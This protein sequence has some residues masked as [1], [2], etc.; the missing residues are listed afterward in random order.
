MKSIW[1]ILIILMVFGFGCNNYKPK[2]ETPTIEKTKMADMVADVHIIESYIQNIDAKQRDSIKTVLYRELFEIH[3]I[4]TTEFYKNQQQYYTN[5]ALVE[6][7]Y[8]D[9]LE[10]LNEKE[11]D[12]MK[13]KLVN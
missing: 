7:L 12:V 2:Y 3:N 11:K 8:K 1:C 13:I 9:V 5:P 4:D 6:D 10:K